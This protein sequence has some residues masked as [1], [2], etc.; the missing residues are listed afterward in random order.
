MALNLKI[1]CCLASHHLHTV[2][3]IYPNI[4]TTLGSIFGLST[5]NSI[6]Q[7][8]TINMAANFDREIE[9]HGGDPDRSISTNDDNSPAFISFCAKGATAILLF[10]R[11]LACL[12][13]LAL[14]AS[15]GLLVA[16]LEA[17]MSRS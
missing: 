2:T 15:R 13:G 7:L 14:W 8:T 4:T 5:Q 1:F 16:L 9:K 10:C 6:Q 3:N 11:N 17:S 12:S